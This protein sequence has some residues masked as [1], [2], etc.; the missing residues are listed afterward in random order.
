MTISS[1]SEFRLRTAGLGDLK[2]VARVWKS[3]FFDDKVIG[4][5][6]HLHCDEYPDDVD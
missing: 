5:P 2:G 4:H 1:K 3:A 6:M